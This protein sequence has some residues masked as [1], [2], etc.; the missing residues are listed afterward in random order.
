ML[1]NTTKEARGYFLLELTKE[2][3]KS[4]KEANMIILEEILKEIIPDDSTEINSDTPFTKEEIIR[5]IKEKQTDKKEELKKIL[6]EPKKELKE[7]IIKPLPILRSPLRKG[8]TLRIIKNQPR[9]LRIPE[10]KLPENL[11]YLKP[12]LTQES[13]D[14]KE[15]NPLIK[16]SNVIE[17]ESE[18]HNHFVKVSG[19]M[20]RKSTNLVLDQNQIDNIL[21]AFSKKAKI[22][23]SVGLTRIVV[24]NL[25]L[26]AIL[27][28]DGETQF[29][30]KKIIPHQR[31]P[32]PRY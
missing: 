27:T 9:V 11:S 22:P 10:P 5:R 29:K 30:I 6:E 20:G 31:T 19:T 14:L 16:D 17:I 3:I 26:T 4:T 7:E 1:I 2:M 8:N 15:V 13:L 18:G 25:I 28:N 32:F 24:G 23:I 21:E 12:S